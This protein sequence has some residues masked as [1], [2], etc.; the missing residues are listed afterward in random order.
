MQYGWQ[1]FNDVVKPEGAYVIS[2]GKGS[3]LLVYYE[4]MYSLLSIG[5]I[6]TQFVAQ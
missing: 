2:L 3:V 4:Y 1:A 5:M 6:D